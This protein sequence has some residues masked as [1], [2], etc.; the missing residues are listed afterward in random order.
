MIISLLEW[1]HKSCLKHAILCNRFTFCPSRSREMNSDTN[2]GWAL[3]FFLKCLLKCLSKWLP[4]SGIQCSSVR[5]NQANRWQYVTF[6]PLSYAFVWAVVTNKAAKRRWWL[7]KC[8]CMGKGWG[9][10]G[11]LKCVFKSDCIHLT[12]EWQCWAM[13]DPLEGE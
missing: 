9:G 1:R 5:W 4:E 3:Y 10:G 2:R 6:S 12:T 8:V 11:R 13:V 7:C